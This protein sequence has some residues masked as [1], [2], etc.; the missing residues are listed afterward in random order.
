MK[1][2]SINSYEMLRP[3]IDLLQQVAVFSLHQSN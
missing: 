1:L 2:P 3:R